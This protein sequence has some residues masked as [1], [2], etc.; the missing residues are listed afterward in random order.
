MARRIWATGEDGSI[1]Y[2]TLTED[3]LDASINAMRQSFYLNEN[4]CV[5]FDVPH[6]RES[7][8]E[9]D[10]LLLETIKDG[11][12]VA[13]IEKASGEV[14]GAVL[15]KLQT[16]GNVSNY[17]KFLRTF[18]HSSSIGVLQ[19]MIDVENR[20]DIFEHCQV[21]SVMELM[22]L[23]VIPEFR[24]QGI[25]K[26]LCEVSVTI[27][28]CLR[29]GR[30][31]RAPYENHDTYELVPPEIMTGIFTAPATQKFA[32]ELNFQLGKRFYFDDFVY[33]GSKSLGQ[34]IH[35]TSY[36]TYEYLRL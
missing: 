34:F 24:R 22:F 20:F 3:L 12:S 17:A 27:A 30:D 18:K 5:A 28:K 1:E 7:F 23:G 15:N 6:H 2:V 10:Q 19:W 13:A 29:D 36:F 16:P 8:E 4:I 33:R 21:D 14:A 26:K 9:L 35:N 31:V 32:R 25:G 11:V